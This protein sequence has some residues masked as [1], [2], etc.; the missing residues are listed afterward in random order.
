MLTYNNLFEKEIKQLVNDEVSRIT[1][2][3]LNGTAIQS[4]EDYRNYTGQ[5]KGLRKI[6]EFCDF[7]Q[8]NLN[9]R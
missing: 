2:V 8:E 4:M 3:I 5:I 7:A 1:E 6:I 9:K